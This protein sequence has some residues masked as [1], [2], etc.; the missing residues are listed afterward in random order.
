MVD[1]GHSSPSQGGIA[2]RQGRVLEGTVISVFE[3]HGFTR[4]SYS[5]WHKCPEK[6]GDEVLVCG[7]PYTSI[8]G[9]RGKTEFLA[10]SKRLNRTIRIE[11]KWQQ[12][13]GSVDEK[14]P[15]LYLNCVQAMPEN[16]IVIILDGGG[17]KEHAVNWLRQAARD[18]LFLEHHP[19]KKIHVL[20][21][22]EF[23]IWGNTTLR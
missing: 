8:Y 11:C 19:D 16:E 12:S 23:L 5:G 1:D 9:H 21:L 4:A 2:N 3:N 7:A 17:A 14:F 20:T 18:R 6:Y 13:A 15:Y 10:I 22:S